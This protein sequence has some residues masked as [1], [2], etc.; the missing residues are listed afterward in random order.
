[1]LEHKIWGD[2][3]FCPWAM[4]NSYLTSEKSISLLVSLRQE[5]WGFVLLCHLFEGFLLWGFLFVLLLLFVWDR[6]SL[7]S[8]G[9]NSDLPVSASWVPP[10]LASCVFTAS[11]EKERR[12]GGDERE[13]KGRL[14]AA[15]INVLIYSKLQTLSALKKVLFRQEKRA[16][17]EIQRV[18]YKLLQN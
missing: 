17:S 4:V 8:P 18:C 14:T 15:E 9:L 2:L 5:L 13:Q 1:M 12:T 6:V 10:K 7:Y 16:E 3:N 11:K